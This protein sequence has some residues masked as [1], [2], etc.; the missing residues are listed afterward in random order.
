MTHDLLEQRG[1]IWNRMLNMKYVMLLT[2]STFAEVYSNS[3][4][5]LIDISFIFIYVFN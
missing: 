3:L 5:L 4:C 2:F 1:N